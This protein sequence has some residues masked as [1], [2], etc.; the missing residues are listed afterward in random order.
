MCRPTDRRDDNDDDDDDDGQPL[1]AWRTPVVR[2]VTG[3]DQN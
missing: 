3:I 1:C 2:R